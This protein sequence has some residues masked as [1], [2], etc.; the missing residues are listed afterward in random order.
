MRL[1]ILSA[2]SALL[3]F[4]LPLTADSAEVSGRI[5]TQLLWYNDIVDASRQ[6]DVSEYLRFSVTHLDKENNISLTGYGRLLW[7]I[8]GSNTRDEVETRLYYLYADYR[9]FLNVSDLRVGRQ[10]VNF[11]AGSA[12]MEGIQADIRDI[13]PVGLVVIGG[14]NVIFGEDKLLTNH[15]YSAGFSVYITGK[16]MNYFDVSYLRTY[17]HGDIARDII[18]S[19]YKQYI[20]ELFKLYANVRYD[21]TAEVLNEILGGI[22]YFPT[23]DLILTAEH[24]QSYPT[25]DSTSIYSVFAVDHFKENIVRADYTAAEWVD[26]NLRYGYESFGEGTDATLYEA[27]LKVR[28]SVQTAIGLFH[29]RRWGYPGDLDGYRVYAEFNNTA[30]WNAAIGIDHDVYNRDNMTGEE[31]AR[32]YWASGRYSFARK[33]SGSFRLQDSVDV[34]YKKDIQGRLTF[35]VDF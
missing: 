13:G 29:D 2:F 15:S 5:S 6:N 32:R 24:Y 27:G 33:M 1:V 21:L 8:K 26:I 18:G 19:S 17:D 23:S 7:N 11:S 4:V 28:P 10:F 14:R 22:K 35:D 12:L 3:F 31:S 16:S 9:N 34:N 25:F 30:K 20:S